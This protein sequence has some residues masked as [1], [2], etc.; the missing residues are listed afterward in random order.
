LC[1]C[2]L[3]RAPATKLIACGRTNRDDGQVTLVVLVLVAAAVFWISRWD[4]RRPDAVEARARNPFARPRPPARRLA[5]LIVAAIAV[6]L[7][8]LAVLPYLD[9]F[10][11]P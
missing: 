2:L 7:V 1:S 11:F 10:R 9:R 4:L 5:G 3:R 6:C 8:A